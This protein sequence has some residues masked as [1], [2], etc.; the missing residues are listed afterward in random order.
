MSNETAESLA[1]IFCKPP[2]EV[3]E[4]APVFSSMLTTPLEGQ[5]KYSFPYMVI[6]EVFKGT[7][8]P[9]HVPKN[10]QRK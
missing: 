5:D 9:T 6:Y 10:F 7:E 1:E 8:R 4:S 2:L 3:V